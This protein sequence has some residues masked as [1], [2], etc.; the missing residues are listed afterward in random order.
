MNR[1]IKL[2]SLGLVAGVFL[3]G[4]AAFANRVPDHDLAGS[5][6]DSIVTRYPGSFIVGYLKKPFDETD[7]ITG[8]YKNAGGGKVPYQIIHVEGAITRIVYLFPED[9]SAVDVMRNYTDALRKANMTI[10]FSCDKTACGGDGS[11][12]FS[13][14]F[15]A[16]KLSPQL[17]Q[18]DNFGDANAFVDASNQSRYAL[19]KATAAD[20]TVTYVSVYVDPP[21]DGAGGIFV[22]IARPAPLQTGQVTVNLSAADMA[23]S[24]AADGRVALYGLQFD[25]DKT[26]LRADSKPSLVE[27]AKLLNQD[28][29]LNVYVVGHTDNQGGYAHNLELS[30]KRSEAIVQVLSTQYKVS[31]AR[32]VAK[33]VASLSPIASNESDTGRAKNRR[34]ELVKQ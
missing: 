5:K 20:G 11:H 21:S 7:L 2:V 15:V 1:Y 19:A 22:E 4:T 28:P 12:N 31:A 26:E 25:T 33:G 32:L 23:K 24:I 14:D 9:R 34:V 8:A 18:W 16:A 3:S 13:S 29:K 27:I 30:Q 17:E 10:V 6:D